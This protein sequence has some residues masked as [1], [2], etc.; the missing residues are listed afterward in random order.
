MGFEP[1]FME[2]FCCAS[3]KSGKNDGFFLAEE[4]N[5][6]LGM[7][8]AENGEGMFEG[9]FLDCWGRSEPEPEGR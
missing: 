2:D 3:Q 1:P 6:D 8:D 4:N 7:I 9:L 5:G